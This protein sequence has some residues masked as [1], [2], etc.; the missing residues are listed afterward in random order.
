[1]NA[2]QIT[3]HAVDWLVIALY[4]V[5]IIGI[6]LYLKKFADS[7]DDGVNDWWV[8]ASLTQH[9]GDYSPEPGGHASRTGID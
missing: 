7:S 5:A 8:Y 4:F 9:G 2:H 6:G 3:L 1:M